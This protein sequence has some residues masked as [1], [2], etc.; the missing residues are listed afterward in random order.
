MDD[1]SVSFCGTRSL[2]DAL[3]LLPKGD[4]CRMNSWPTSENSVIAKFGETAFYEVGV[5]R[6]VGQGT[7]R[8]ERKETPGYSPAP[9]TP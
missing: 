7:P 3:F 6:W 2:M 8:G 5:Q 9:F 4:E 1:A